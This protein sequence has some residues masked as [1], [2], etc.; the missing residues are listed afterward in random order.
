MQ[1]QYFSRA[2]SGAQEVQQDTQGKANFLVVLELL[3]SVL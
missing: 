3:C 1:A 2:I